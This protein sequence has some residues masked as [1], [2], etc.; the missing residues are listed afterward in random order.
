MV[1]PSK[2]SFNQTEFYQHTT[3]DMRNDHSAKIIRV[4]LENNWNVRFFLEIPTCFTMFLISLLAACR[5]SGC[6]LFNNLASSCKIYP[7]VN[8]TAL[9]VN[10]YNHLQMKLQPYASVYLYICTVHHYDSKIN[11]FS[12]A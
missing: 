12:K 4:I 7:V 6:L 1:M 3:E 5:S 9:K 8:K 2:N 10:I 11:L